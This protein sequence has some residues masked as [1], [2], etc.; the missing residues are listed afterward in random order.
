[1]IMNWD[2]GTWNDSALEFIPNRA[3][4]VNG[5]VLKDG[6]HRVVFN[7]ID[8]QTSAHVIVE[9]GQFADTTEKFIGTAVKNAD[10]WGTFIEGFDY[11]S[12]GDLEVI[13]GS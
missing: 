9:N 6:V 2:I 10:Y 4:T 13:I 1:M 11:D 3:A 12:N 5:K 7:Y 8:V